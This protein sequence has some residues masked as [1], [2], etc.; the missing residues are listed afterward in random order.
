MFDSLWVIWIWFSDSLSFKSLPHLAFQ[1]E[2]KKQG[3]AK[4]SHMTYDLITSSPKGA[5]RTR[6]TN[7]GEL[8]YPEGIALHHM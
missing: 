8:I 7:Q 3:G 6:V 2:P 1:V 5:N 4:K